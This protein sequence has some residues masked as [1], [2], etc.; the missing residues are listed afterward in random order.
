MTATDKSKRRLLFDP[1]PTDRDITVKATFNV[2]TISPHLNNE[3]AIVEV[4]GPYAYRPSH[5]LWLRRVY[6]K[7]RNPMDD[8]QKWYHVHDQAKFDP[9]LPRTPPSS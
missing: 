8:Y 1:V 3:Q 7:A 9:E 2:D 5:N 6:V 4:E